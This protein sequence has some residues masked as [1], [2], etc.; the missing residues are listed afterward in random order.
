M[1]IGDFFMISNQYRE[2]GWFWV[3]TTKDDVYVTPYKMGEI[4]SGQDVKLDVDL[5]EFKLGLRKSEW[6][7]TDWHIAPQVVSKKTS[8]PR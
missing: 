7:F 5:D 6:S 3:V 1:R 8:G 2:S 4:K